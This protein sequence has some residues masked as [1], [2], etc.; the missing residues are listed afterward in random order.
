MPLNSLINDSEK[1][2]KGNLYIVATPIGNRDDITIRALK[3]L[4]Q[5][6][7]IAA[8]DTRHTSRFLL[9][10]NIKGNLVSC[11]EHNEK[12]RTQGLIKKLKEGLSVALVSNAGT[13]SVADPGYYLI[14]SAIASNIKVIPIPGVS[15]AITALSAAGLP[16]DSFIFIGFLSKTKNKR[17]KQLRELAN[18]QRTIIFY[19][20]PKRILMLLKELIDVMGDRYS[21]LSREMTKLYEEFIRG[22]LSEIFS[23]LQERPV[24]KGECTLL[25]TGCKENKDVSMEFVRSEIKNRLKITGTRLSELVKEIAKKYNLP[26]NKVYDEALKVKGESSKPCL[27]GVFVQ[28]L[29]SEDCQKKKK[30]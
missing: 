13:P 26:K 22:S 21:V 19:E 10:H 30:E 11:H 15:A 14:K 8:E 25:I 17:F 23:S 7:I 4:E 5:A 27:N 1:K 3:I 16:T 2:N 18:E 9:H 28:A 20:S 24:V 29:T 6:D 12:K